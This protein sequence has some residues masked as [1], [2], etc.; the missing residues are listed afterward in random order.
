ML[1][2][3]TLLGLLPLIGVNVRTGIIHA[4]AGALAALIAGLV[5]ADPQD[6]PHTEVRISITDTDVRFNIAMNLNY[7][8]EIAPTIREFPDVVDPT[9]EGLIRVEL[10]K[11]FLD[12]NQVTI[13]G[14]EVR[15]IIESFEFIR[16]DRKNLKLFPKTGLKALTRFS[17][18]VS[19]PFK[20]PPEVVTM[21]WTGYPED[22]FSTEPLGPDGKLPRL[23]VQALLKAEGIVTQIVFSESDPVVEWRPSH[24][25]IDDR[26]EEV[27]LPS[28]FQ[29]P[30][31][32]VASAL[33]IASWLFTSAIFFRK[34][35]GKVVLLTGVSTAVVA[36]LIMPLATMPIGEPKVN[37]EALLAVFRP[38]HTNVY[39][40]F[41]YSAESDIYDALKRSVSGEMLE[42]LYTSIHRGLVQAEQGG[43]V[44]RITKVI[45]DETTVTGID[46]ASKSFT[47]EAYWIV[48]GTVY[49]WGHSHPK[50]TVYHANYTIA[51]TEGKWRIVASEVLSSEHLNPEPV[52]LPEGTGL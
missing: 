17:F 51:D 47:I 44:G 3:H 12:D 14:V 52:V 33:I 21:R 37:D 15:G 38:L 26:L 41:D 23:I 46:S 9:E 10:E 22:S 11:F 29:T 5:Y 8:D 40:A 7:V 1:A 16:L 2:S 45:L 19:Y 13:D 31:F 39:R 36:V 49:H 25:T 50:Q 32:P 34:L 24:A 6:G 42:E 27:P 30:T 35:G 4:V 20:T 28:S 43:S 48:E 18:V